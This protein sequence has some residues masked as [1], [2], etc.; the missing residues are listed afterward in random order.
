MGSFSAA[1]LGKELKRFGAHVRVLKLNGDNSHKQ[2]ERVTEMF[3]EGY[4]G[5]ISKITFIDI[6]LKG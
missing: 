6:I 1:W 2:K 5:Y 3:K 4:K